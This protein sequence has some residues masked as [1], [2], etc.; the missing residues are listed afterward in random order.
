MGV[1]GELGV[2]VEVLPA[3][4]ARAGEP[5]GRLDAVAEAGR[6]RRAARAR[7][8]RAA[9]GRRSRRRTARRPRRRTGAPARAPSAG[10]R[11]EAL[12]ARRRAPSSGTSASGRSKPGRR[13][14]ALDLAGEQRRRAGSPAPRRRCPR[15]RPGSP[16]LIAS[17]LRRTS[18]AVCGSSRPA[19]AIS[20]GEKTCG[21]RR[22]SL[23]WQWS[24]TAR[25]VT[26]AALLEQQREEVDLEEDV[27]ELVEE[28][29]VVAGVRGV[30]ELVGLLDRVRDDRALVLLAVPGALAAQAARQLVQPAEGLLDLRTAH[31]AET[32]ARPAR[33]GQPAGVVCCGGVWR[34][35]SAAAAAGAR[36]RAAPVDAG[37]GFEFVQS[38]TM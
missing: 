17:Q 38:G 16:A 33:C 30:G 21:W 37:F 2:E 23:S 10:G 11:R 5:L 6:W 26:G 3:L 36:R 15:S 12:D 34:R 4:A 27:A 1:V 25:E 13:G 31:R 19:S 35:P 9:C 22:T 7:D 28:L 14:A 32:E 20:S 18:P 24:A 8:R 29:G